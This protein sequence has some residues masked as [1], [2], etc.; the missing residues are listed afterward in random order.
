MGYAI[1]VWETLPDLGSFLQDY[2]FDLNPLTLLFGAST[3]ATVLL[4]N[5]SIPTG[6]RYT[7]INNSINIYGAVIESDAVING[8]FTFRIIQ[9]NGAVADRTFYITLTPVLISPTWTTQPTFLGYQANISVKSYLLTATTTTGDHLLYDLPFQPSSA[10]IGIHTGVFT[11]NPIDVFSDI[12]FNT[13]VRA[14]DSVTGADS[15]V[16]VSIGVLT[17][18]TPP[19]WITH[20]GS[21]GEYYGETFVEYQLQSEDPFST[22]VIYGLVSA[23]ANFPLMVADTGL[24]YGTLPVVLTPTTWN[25]V[26]N[27]TSIN[28]TTEQ[29]FSI[30]VQPSIINASFSWNTPGDLGMIE[31]GRYVSI[32]IEAT[33]DIN[34]TIIY[35]ITGGLLPPHLILGSTNGIIEG[36]CEYTAVTKTY[37]FD[38]TAYDGNQ[39]IIQQFSLT[40]NKI[41]SN[42]YFN[43]YLPMTGDLRNSWDAD[44]TN[45]RIR[46][47]GTVK[48]DTISNLPNPP[49]LSIINGLVTGYSTP[50]QILSVIQPW[51]NELNLQIG[52]SA[53]TATISNG[54]SVIYRNIVDNQSGANTIVSDSYVFGGDV[55]PI[56]INNIRSALIS[57]Y[58]FIG[59]GS[60]TGVAVLPNLNYNNGSIMSVAVLDSGSGYLSPPEIVV[61]GSGSGAIL[62]SVLGLVGATIIN[63]TSGWNLGSTLQIFSYDVITPA[64]LTVTEV[65][66]IGNI[67]SLEITY[68]G[69][70]AQVSA[71]SQTYIIN[72]NLTATVGLSWGVVAVVVVA[73]GSDYQCGIT[74]STAGSELLD[75]WQTAYSPTVE[76]GEISPATA[77]Q[78]VNILNYEQ[79]TLLGTPWQPTMMVMQWQGIK[80]IGSTIFDNDTTTFDGNSTQ[81]QDTESPL[82]TVFDDNREIFD[83]NSTIFDYQDP[84]SY[85]LFQVW[86]GTLIDAGTTVFDLYSTI[87]DALGPRTYSNTRLQKWI[88]T[89]N[90]IYSGNNAVW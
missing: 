84:L 47:P 19:I 79:S 6:L 60:G 69:S 11:Y 58:P 49:I 50:D 57:V 30:L 87:F 70:Y 40:V 33:S 9:S 41:Y 67:I 78:A 45:I 13:V 43:A 31:E 32:N 27:A 10:N 35:N 86:G 21:I 3:G 73:G 17:S 80:W 34:S 75:I 14:T 68:S 88:T 29:N 18:P 15:N 23:D 76:V 59:S 2:S 5:G 56:S 89:Q 66:D 63:S 25:F 12:T 1:P 74:L 26:V 44:T 46:A 64:L 16:T 22:N 24:L 71:D 82:E 28:G 48:F 65:D 53:N 54:L 8:Q 38:I 36:F 81:F 62:Q 90:K 72:G 85:D 39:Y 7:V 51:W 61:G 42:Q 55:Y 20:T 77:Q 4:I 83:N 52:S 37:Y